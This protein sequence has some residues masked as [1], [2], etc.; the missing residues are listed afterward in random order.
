MTKT[1]ESLFAAL[2]FAERAELPEPWDKKSI[3]INAIAK[4]VKADGAHYFVYVEKGRDGK[5][6]TIKDFG[7]TSITR[8]VEEVYPLVYLESSYLSKFP[9]TEEGREKQIQYLKYYRVNLDF[10]SMDKKALDKECIKVAIQQQL[11]DEKRKDKIIIK[12]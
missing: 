2:Q 3:Y 1:E 9:K 6:R 10:A 12:Y 4:V 7:A 11:A 5:D 8:K